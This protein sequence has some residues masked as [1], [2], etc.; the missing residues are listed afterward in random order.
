MAEGDA[1][2][3]EA[4]FR[5][6]LQIDANVPELHA[7][8]ALLLDQQGRMPSAED[9]YRQALALRP[10]LPEVHLNLGTLLLCSKRFDEAEAALHHALSMRPNDAASWTNLGV[11]HAC[12]K[13][14]WAAEA[15]HHRAL[16][17]DPSL[18][19]AA[20]NLAYVL[21]RQ[22]RWAEGWPALERRPSSA[23]LAVHFAAV[24]RWQGEPLDGRSILLGFEAGQG[25]MIMFL[26]YVGEVRAR[27]AGAI[28]LLCHPSLKRLC[29]ELLCPAVEHVIAFNDP[30]PRVGW[31]CWS[32]LMSLPGLCGTTPDRVPAALPYLQ[33]PDACIDAARAWLP[34]RPH[35]GPAP[36]R[37]GLVWRGNP[38]F[39]ND[40]AR[41]LPSLAT[42]APLG[43]AAHEAGWAVQWVSLQKGM[44]E[45]EAQTPPAEFRQWCC[46]SAHLNDFVDTAAVVAQLDLV[47]AVDTAVAHLAGALDRPC[48]LL[49]P[50]YKTDWRWLTAR[51]DTPW[52]PGMCLFRQAE[53]EAWV[54]TVARVAAL[55]KDAGD[56]GLSRPVL[57]R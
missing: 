22:G 14:D 23:A 3:A 28:T 56:P 54:A 42:L 51:E 5:Q 1:A 55:F 15:C 40:A 50:D 34:E 43:A 44:G 10:D 36:L 18:D 7:N 2:G 45:D 16:S 57:S 33:V 21:L 13:R 32:P 27:G 35:G 26:R 52:Y 31:D 49:L 47:I 19:S 38:A 48:W 8:L 53:G 9:H 11:L 4:C 20:V 41:S 39:E 46:P 29:R 12:L 6:A 17:L 24:P 37:I 25:D 30:V